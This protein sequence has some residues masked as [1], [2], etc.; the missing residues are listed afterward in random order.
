MAAN[1][2][3]HL[4]AVDGVAHAPSLDPA[5]H[6][7][8][9][10]V[11]PPMQGRDVANLQRAT[12]ERL[13]HH[14][15]ADDPPVPTHGKFTPATALAC[16]EAQYWLGLRSDTYLRRDVHGHR[17]VTEGAQRILREPDTRERDQLMR[18]KQRAMHRD[19]APAFFKAIA[20]DLGI[21][22]HG[23]EDALAFAAEHVGVK[24]HPPMSNSGGPILGWCKAA[25]YTGP[26]PWCGC[27]VNACLMAGGLPSG[28]GWIG[29]TPSILARAKAGT[30]GW[31]LHTTGMAGDLALYDD[32]PGGDPVVHVEIVRKRLSATRYSCY[33]GNTSS[34]DGSP[35]DGGMVARHDDRSTMG[36]FHIIGFA[37]PPWKD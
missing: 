20:R 17:V 4:A 27:F 22:G 6:R 16:I 30:A 15:P 18:A 33:G 7:P 24:E 12:R 37:R 21:G 10:A 26:V 9:I 36:A 28:A 14:G 8:L 23:V 35:N 13:R 19:Q 34:G 3:T 32:K 11:H 1:P 2:A 25:G 5:V 29:Y 31:S